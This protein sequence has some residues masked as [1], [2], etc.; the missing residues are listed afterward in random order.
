MATKAP[1]FSARAP[2]TTS[3]DDSRSARST[4]RELLDLL[5]EEACSAES[6]VDGESLGAL[7]SYLIVLSSSG[8]SFGLKDDRVR[9]ADMIQYVVSAPE[10]PLTAEEVGLQPACTYIL[11]F[12]GTLTSGAAGH[13][14]QLSP[15]PTLGD[16]SGLSGVHLSP[17]RRRQPGN[18]GERFIVFFL[19]CVSLRFPLFSVCVFVLTCRSGAARLS[20]T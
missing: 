16:W 2:A 14:R 8:E 5:S 6:I 4:P 1:P 11:I 20:G 15:R 9:L 12:S 19:V 10:D 18:P 13:C 3:P 7:I 17:P